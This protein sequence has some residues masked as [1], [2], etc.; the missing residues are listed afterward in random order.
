MIGQVFS[1]RYEIIERVGGGGMALVYK[2]LDLLLNRF[3]AV[4]VLRQ[5]FMHDDEFIR[6]F[7]REAQ[8]A[9][10]LSHPNIVSIYDV[11]Q[12]GEVQY[13]VMEYIEGRD[14]DEVIKERAPLPT[15]EAVRIA[16]QICDALDHA[17]N[18]QI[19]HRDIKPH[20]ILIGRNGRVKVTDFGIARAVTSTTITQTGSVVGSVHYFSPEH[21]KGVAAG[22]KSDLYSLGIVMYQMLTGALPYQGESPISV[23]LKHLQDEYEEPRKLNPMIPQSVENIIIRAMRKNPAERYASAS[24]MQRNL[25]TCLLPSRRDEEKVNFEEVD[26]ADRT[27]VVPAI[28]S[29]A[30]PSPEMQRGDP[31]DGSK[32]G[33]AA[34]KKNWKKPAIIIGSTLLVLLI[35]LLVVL[36]VR[37][38]VVV[39]DTTVPNVLGLT[40]DAARTA[41]AEKML[42][43]EGVK[44]EYDPSTEPGIVF[45]QSKPEGLTVKQGASVLLTVGAE[46]PLSKMPAVT[47]GTYDD[48][49]R[50]LAALGVSEDR[51]KSKEVFD[52]A[53]AGTVIAQSPDANDQFDPDED[54]VQLTVS[55]GVENMTV[56]DVTGKTRDQAVAAINAQSLAPSTSEE[57]SYTVEQGKVISQAP[58]SG[59]EVKPGSTVK[60]VVSTG[61]PPEALNF[62]LNL[63]VE[64][65]QEGAASKISIEYSD[66]R[67]E[68]IDFG[69]ATI[70]SLRI[71]QI[72]LV[73]APNRNGSVVVLRDGEYV[74]SYTVDYTGAKDGTYQQPKLPEKEPEVTPPPEEDPV[75]PPAEEPGGDPQGG[76]EGDGA[77]ETDGDGGAADT[78]PPPEDNTDAQNQDGTD[79]Q[80]DDPGQPEGG[81]ETDPSALVPSGKVENVSARAP[82]NG[83]GHDKAVEHGNGR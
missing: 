46:K 17:H 76:Q 29:Y 10:S 79:Q 49:L 14:L 36:Y 55:K 52:E 4:K 9:A 59:T 43:V 21:A 83:R 75:E 67:G 68:H 25:D 20:N 32:K 69:T 7:R 3:V 78:Q 60:I 64:P 18:N 34:G 22:E 62:T 33:K 45:K 1:G 13:I 19:I 47:D 57:P 27:L 66:A 38:Q 77:G 50:Q 80:Q 40:E 42:E 35:A 2:A 56:P 54:V 16:S 44:K 41:L 73:L 81:E 26:D 24:E 15:E 30:P 37:N 51:V 72:P 31:A 53:E 8:S 63:P 82:V 58:E 70:S 48:A 39:K 61:V 23:A 74:D 12:D 6:R 11:G 71:F 5:Q 65:S 28:R